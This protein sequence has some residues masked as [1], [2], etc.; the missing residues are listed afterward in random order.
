MTVL[1]TVPAA[2]V[3]VPVRL[4]TRARVPFWFVNRVGV[5]TPLNFQ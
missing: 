2:F 4:P 5:K 3:T 1:R